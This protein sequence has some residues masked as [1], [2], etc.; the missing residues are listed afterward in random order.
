MSLQSYSEKYI[1]EFVYGATDGTVTTFAIISGVMGAGL[2]PVI[3]LIL[4]ISNV[5]ADGFS[6][7]SSDYLSSRS[8]ED[9]QQESAVKR[10]VKTALV[11]F[12]SFISIGTIPLLPF[13]IA[14]ISDWFASYVFLLSIIFTGLAFIIIGA[15]RGKVTQ[16]NSIKTSLETLLVG[17]I[18]AGI[19]FTVGY[20]L[21]G[22]A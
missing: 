21:K 15:I 20:L 14:L 2:S 22:L 10:P 1:A 16:Q 6:M 4:G 5:L 9:M 8:E 3:V 7:A 11:T 19:A 17:S 12:V 18:A 13:I